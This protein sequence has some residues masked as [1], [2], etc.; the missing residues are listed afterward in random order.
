ML[1]RLTCTAVIALALA[2]AACGNGDDGG[3]AA[4]TATRPAAATAVAPE[5]GTGIDVVDRTIA[6]LRDEDDD[7]LVALIIT[8]QLPCKDETDIGGPPPCRGA[9][10]APP[11]GTPVDVFAYLT[12]EREWQFDLPTFARRFN[13]AAGDLYAVVRFGEGAPTGELPPG[14]YGVIVSSANPQ[15]ETA[16]ALILS[17]GGIVHADSLCGGTPADF[18][19]DVPPFYAPELIFEGPAYP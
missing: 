1:T 18:L 19:A 8:Q 3:R 10:G 6:A 7:A 4:P 16:H 15:F 9:P 17:Q 14:R 13:E 12:C 5:D 2:A 11:D